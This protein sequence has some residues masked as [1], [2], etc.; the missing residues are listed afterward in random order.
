M[1]ARPSVC[2]EV[3]EI[4]GERVGCAFLA[5]ERKFENFGSSAL[6]ELRVDSTE[7]RKISDP[8]DT[9]TTKGDPPHGPW[10]G[11]SSLERANFAPVP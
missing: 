2:L 9:G 3:F 4:F 5:L 11:F 6:P 7:R 8:G 1:P 10:V